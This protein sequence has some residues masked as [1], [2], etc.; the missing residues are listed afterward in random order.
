MRATARALGL[1]HD[2]AHQGRDGQVVGASKIVRD[3]T[4]GGSEAERERFRHARREQHDFIGI[5]DLEASPFS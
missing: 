5:C 3:I 4:D 1:A 2:L